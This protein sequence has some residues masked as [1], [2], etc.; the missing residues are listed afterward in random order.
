MPAP[1]QTAADVVAH[2]YGH[3]ICSDI[4]PAQGAFGEGYGDTCGI[5]TDAGSFVTSL[6]RVAA[7]SGLDGVVASPQEIK[8]IRAAVRQTNFLIVTPGIRSAT[9]AADDQRRTMTAA[10][11]LRAGAD[12]LVIGR[13]ITAASD[14]TRATQ[15]IVAEITN[16]TNRHR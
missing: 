15:C 12:Y 6:A 9:D 4:Y 2:E 1:Y 11:A 3:H 16:A 8:I 10:E 13:P 14:R 5:H 7:A